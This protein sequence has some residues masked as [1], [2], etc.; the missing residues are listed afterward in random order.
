M[1]KGL[2]IGSMDFAGAR[3]RGFDYVDKSPFVGKVLRIKGD[4]LVFCRPRRFGKTLNLTMLRQ[5]LHHPRG[6]RR[7]AQDPFRGMSVLG[8]ELAQ[9]HREKHCIVYLSLKCCKAPTWKEN[10]SSLAEEL[11]KTWKAL[12]FA[13]EQVPTWFRR[14]ADHLAADTLP[15]GKLHLALGQIV[16]AAEEIHGDKVWLLIDEYDAPV[17]TAWQYGFYEQAVRFFRAFFTAALKDCTAVQ[18]AVMTGILRVSK[19]GFFSE[20]NNVVID[21]VLDKAFATD[22]GFTEDEVRDL[23]GDDHQ[24]MDDLRDWYNGYDFSGNGIYNPW[25]VA[26][27]L[28]RLGQPMQTHWMATAGAELI[29]WIATRFA[30]DSAKTLE[31]LLAGEHYRMQVLEGTEIP[32]IDRYP[33][34]LLNVMLHTGYLTGVAL[35]RDD[36]DDDRTYALVRLPNREVRSGCRNILSSVFDAYVPVDGGAE[37]LV[38]ALLRGDESLAQDALQAIILQM[39][40]YHD[41]ADKTPERIYHVFVLGILTRMPRGYRVASNKEFGEGRPDVVMEPDAADRPAALLEFKTAPSP[42][43]ACAKAAAQI[44]QKRYVDGVRGQ[45]VYA[46]AVGFSGKGVVVRLVGDGRAL[47]KPA[48]SAQPCRHATAARVWVWPARHPLLW[49]T[50]CARLPIPFRRVCCLLTPKYCCVNSR[51]RSTPSESPT[52]LSS[53][54]RVPSSPS[55]WWRPTLHW[56]APKLRKRVPKATGV[57]ASSMTRAAPRPVSAGSAG[58]T[59][60]CATM[61]K[62]RATTMT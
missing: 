14:V 42:K 34:M 61:S 55:N 36:P 2:P 53:A 20:L 33:G 5:W 47:D 46:W 37:V 49:S 15:H 40:S 58:C 60:A 35:P 26:N 24:L 44:V 16:R 11:R 19:A 4:V 6:E 31:R 41:L 48:Q 32:R 7:P 27:A 51:P 8:D 45:P 52:W 56:L 10:L 43:A 59:T 13:P 29:Q 30:T 54:W 39:L 28:D 9:Q 22:F 50:P 25:S 38:A 21:T 1:P 17:Q 62:P 18:R 3:A 12:G 57:R 23:C